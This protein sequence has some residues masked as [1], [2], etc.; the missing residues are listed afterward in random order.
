[1]AAELKNEFGAGVRL[2]KGKDGIFDV[3]VDGT[4]VF[5][6]HTVGRFPD[7]GEV[8]GEIRRLRET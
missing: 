3:Q 1:L 5:S 4:L 6:K 2:I 8:Q 7:P